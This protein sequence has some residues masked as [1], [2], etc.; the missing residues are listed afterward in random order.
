MLSVLNVISGHVLLRTI[1]CTV[2]GYIIYV[3]NSE[4]ILTCRY[5]L[6]NSGA[7]FRSFLRDTDCTHFDNMKYGI[8]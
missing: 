6:V 7:I 1:L 2:F 4:V 8:F 3:L 5:N